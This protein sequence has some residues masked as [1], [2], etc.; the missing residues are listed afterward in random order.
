LLSVLSCYENCNG[1]LGEKLVR[2]IHIEKND[3]NIS[4]QKVCEDVDNRLAPGVGDGPFPCIGRRR[5][6]SV[7][8]ALA[9]PGQGEGRKKGDK[10][11]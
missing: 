4:S 8:V 11:L 5:G 9:G 6:L 1:L 7:G 2:K 10:Y 3:S